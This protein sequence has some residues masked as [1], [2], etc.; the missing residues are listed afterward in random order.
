MVEFET[1]DLVQLRGKS[2]WGGGPFE[3]ELNYNYF[4]TIN[5][6]E[7]RITIKVGQPVVFEKLYGYGHFWCTDTLTGA[8]GIVNLRHF[9]KVRKK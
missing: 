8:R 6:V 7:T 1:G 3:R 2:V 5:K 4:D 9:K